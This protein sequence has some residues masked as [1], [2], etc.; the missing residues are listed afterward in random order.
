ME[1]PECHIFHALP[2]HD[3]AFDVAVIWHAT[4]VMTKLADMACMMLTW[5]FLGT[6][7]T[8]FLEFRDVFGDINV[9]I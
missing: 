2:V 5:Q 6:T 8:I 1:K 4:W 3:V 9:D 7:S